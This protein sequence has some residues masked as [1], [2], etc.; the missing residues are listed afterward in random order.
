MDQSSITSGSAF[1]TSII[2]ATAFLAAIGLLT[3]LLVD[4]VRTALQ[5]ELDDQLLDEQRFIEEILDD[6]DENNDVSVTQVINDVISPSPSHQSLIGL[7]DQT[8]TRIAGN[9]REL[10][11]FVGWGLVDEGTNLDG[12]PHAHRVHVQRYK[13]FTT[14]VG[15]ELTQI[16]ST[17]RLIL[18]IIIV[19]CLATTAV[20]FAIG[21]FLSR[22]TFLKLLTMEGILARTSHGEVGLSLPIST[23]NDQVD[24][25]SRQMNAHLDRLTILI[26]TVRSTGAAIAHEL[27]TPLTRSSLAVQN[28]R[29]ALQQG[30][31]VEPLLTL[32]LEEHER[33]AWTF[34]TILHIARIENHSGG[35]EPVAISLSEL[36]SETVEDFEP[37]AHE[38]AQFLAVRSDTSHGHV[39]LGDRLMIRQL[40]VNL[41]QNALSHCPRGTRITVSATTTNE[42]PTLSVCD[43]GPGVPA[44]LRPEIFEPFVRAE[45]KA[46]GDG[47]GLGL[48]LVRAI[49]ERHGAV[50]TVEDA[51][52]G[53]CFKVVFPR[54][55]GGKRSAPLNHHN[56][57]N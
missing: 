57:T 39:V 53:S 55:G 7:F 30:N 11:E 24:R 9:V 29:T 21:Y 4:D 27:K 25:I 35:Y 16:D 37:I 56:T 46:K 17:L 47:V 18:R 23:A 12:E 44:S 49:A 1:K 10:P 8:G 45:G 32:A 34:E 42:H 6:T 54:K 31:D 40:L 50:C 15:Q 36:A 14:V 5:A 38:N 20:A 19:V 3:Y 52:P 33:L 2:V 48:A 41:V 51:L 26:E 28:A 22:K 13:N 43:D